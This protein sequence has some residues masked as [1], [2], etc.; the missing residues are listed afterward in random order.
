MPELESILE[1][2]VAQR[3][4]FVVV[5]DFAAIAHG[6]TLV[7]ADIEICCRFAPENLKRLY[8]A[9]SDLHPVHR[10]TPQRLP[11]E[12]TSENCSRFKNLYLDTDFG[13]L[14]CLGSILR[15]GDYDEA[16][17]RSLTIEL[18]FGDCQI[19]GIDALIEA[20]EAMNRP[21]DRAAIVQLRAIKEQTKQ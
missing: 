7:T 17:R 6:V 18:P 13:Q 15:V 9:I 5:G 11:L 19:L 4:E 3:V 1:R 2:L 14:D 12:L 16:Q 8:D 10:M 21:R 20:K